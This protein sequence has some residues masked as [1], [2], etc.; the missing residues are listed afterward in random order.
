MWYISLWTLQ[1]PHHLWWAYIIVCR[2]VC[3]CMWACAELTEQLWSRLQ[4]KDES[5]PAGRHQS[6]MD[7]HIWEE[8]VRDRRRARREQ[9]T[10]TLLHCWALTLLRGRR[11][12]SVQPSQAYP[13]T[14][15]SSQ[16]RG[17]KRIWC[18][19]RKRFSQSTDS[20][21]RNKQVISC[22]LASVKFYFLPFIASCPMG[23]ENKDGVVYMFS[24]SI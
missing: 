21:S 13:N 5:S 7:W 8:R 10:N 11:V 17:E 1:K 6:L 19:V 15:E 18:N 3:S 24:L 22:S 9:T 12:I 16:T 2:A 23:F 14:Y 20:C 4:V